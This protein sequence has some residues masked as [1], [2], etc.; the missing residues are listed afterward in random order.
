MISA[1]ASLIRCTAMRD[2]LQL[3][4]LGRILLG[5]CHEVNAASLHIL[6]KLGFERVTTQQGSFG[7]MHVLRL[8]G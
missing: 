5:N 1:T 7:N 8:P 3:N 6:H 2:D 4:A